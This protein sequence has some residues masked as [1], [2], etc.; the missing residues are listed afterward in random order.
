MDTPKSA[1]RGG[2]EKMLQATEIGLLKTEAEAMV[3]VEEADAIG[4]ELVENQPSTP[5]SDEVAGFENASQTPEIMALQKK[6]DDE[7]DFALDLADVLEAE[8]R[9]NVSPNE[10]ATKGA[11]IHLEQ[12]EA[13]YARLPEDMKNSTDGR[14]FKIKIDTIGQTVR[15]LEA[16]R[17]AEDKID[18]MEGT[19]SETAQA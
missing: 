6:L 10:S 3:P 13:L 18:S 9:G 11:R 17:L 15:D 16:M 1:Q 5:E 19:Q 7:L 14:D 8:K 12:W 2:F 4:T